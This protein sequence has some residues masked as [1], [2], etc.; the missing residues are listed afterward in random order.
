[1]DRRNISRGFSL[2]AAL[3]AVL[4]MDSAAVPTASADSNA[5][6]NPITH[7]ATNR[8]LDASVSGGVTIKECNGSSYQRW[9]YP[10]GDPTNIQS[11]MCLDGSISHG[12]RL[13]TCN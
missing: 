7:D 12:V 13:A 8:C 1:M 9:Y 6:G 10:N 2:A 11:G 4:I 3:A 5:T